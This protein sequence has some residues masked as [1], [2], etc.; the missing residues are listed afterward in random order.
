MRVNDLSCSVE[1]F[2]VDFSRS[3]L[4]G[5]IDLFVES[6]YGA[7]DRESKKS[8]HERVASDVYGS[9]IKDI[10]EI[11]QKSVR[12]NLE[13]GILAGGAL[14]NVEMSVDLRHKGERAEIVVKLG[15]Y[16]DNSGYLKVV[17]LIREI[18]NEVLVQFRK[19]R[20]SH[21]RLQASYEGIKYLYT[22]Y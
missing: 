14:F 21:K 15:H 13:L 8:M 4:I 22:F 9:C 18:F 2:E 1:V 6:V 3:E 5:I 11:F 7:A 16:L 20:L 12:D 17:K 19:D 10:A